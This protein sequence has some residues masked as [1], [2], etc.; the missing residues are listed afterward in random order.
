MLS[1]WVGSASTYQLFASVQLGTTIGVTSP[2]IGLTSL[3]GEPGSP[4]LSQ[5]VLAVHIRSGGTSR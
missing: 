3:F 4:G 2:W 5:T 1:I